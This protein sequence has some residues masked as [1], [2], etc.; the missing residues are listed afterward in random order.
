[1]IHATIELMDGSRVGA[2]YEYQP[3]ALGQV[4][5]LDAASDYR[6]YEVVELLDMKPREYRDCNTGEMRQMAVYAYR[7]REIKA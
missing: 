3:V 1:M 7:A 6:R 5:E 4:M 2:C